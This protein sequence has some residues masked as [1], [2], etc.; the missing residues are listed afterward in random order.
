MT[1]ADPASKRYPDVPRAEVRNALWVALCEA[2][3]AA[4]E[5]SRAYGASR[6]LIAAARLNR[7][8][9]YRDGLMTA[10]AMLTAQ[11]EEDVYENLQTGL[12]D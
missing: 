3:R 5:L 4:Y 6:G 2:H 10:Y 12:A 9:G 8:R 7:A 11:S 1:T